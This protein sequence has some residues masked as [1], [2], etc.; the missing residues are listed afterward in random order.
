MAALFQSR[1]AEL[2]ELRSKQLPVN[3]VEPQRRPEP[4]PTQQEPERIIS[5]EE[6]M[7]LA[8]EEATDA[9]SRKFL[10]EGMKLGALAVE[11]DRP[12]PRPG[13]P[14]TSLG[15]DYDFEREMLG[16]TPLRDRK[17]GR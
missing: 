4:L 2:R 3:I 16:T 8:F 11:G 12:A 1:A 15:A 13:L 5:P 9:R 7:R 10:S 14:K 17:P 6:A